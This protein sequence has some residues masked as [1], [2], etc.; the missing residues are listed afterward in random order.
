MKNKLL[1]CPIKTTVTISSFEQSTDNFKG[2]VNA[3]LSLNTFRCLTTHR[4]LSS[5]TGLFKTFL[6]REVPTS[7]A[8]AES[9]PG[10][11]GHRFDPGPRLTK[12]VKNGTGCSSLDTQ[13]YRVELGLVD[14]VSG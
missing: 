9:A 10:K 7:V 5:D 12:V 11:G 2:R 6:I 8:Q 13:T 1:S 14:P 3:L 4:I